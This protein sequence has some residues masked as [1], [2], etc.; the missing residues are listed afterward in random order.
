[1][2]W[3]HSFISVTQSI[4]HSV[5]QPTHICTMKIQKFLILF[6]AAFLAIAAYGEPSPHGGYAIVDKGKQ[7]LQCY[8]NG[9][10]VV[11]GPCG[12]G[13]AFEEKNT[14]HNGRHAV[15]AKKA[16]H[17]W[18][19]KYQAWM[20]YPVMFTADGDCLHGSKAFRTVI[21][22]KGVER[23]LTQSHGCV[24]MSTEMAKKVYDVMN[25]GDVVE[26]VGDE[27]DSLK[28]LGVDTLFE[29]YQDSKGNYH[30]RL[31][32]AGPNPTP[33]DRKRALEA[34]AGHVLMSVPKGEADLSKIKVGFPS[35]PDESRMPFLDF[36]AAVG[37]HLTIRHSGPWKK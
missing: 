9:K 7:W 25:V 19:E 1:M 26:I 20:E 12:T 18:S 3:S 37:T 22:K 13:V 23:G 15:I 32:V 10:L 8:E 36:Q 29:K 28:G 6:V 31:K 14:T 30:L 27:A 16:S 2:R 21:D 33:E 4:L 35:L 5:N 17:Y 24:R 34:W 11:E